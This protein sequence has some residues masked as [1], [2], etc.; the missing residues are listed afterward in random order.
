M[1]RGQPPPVLWLM[2]DERQGAALW[3]A[4]ARLPGGAGII[5]RHY[6]TPPAERR[7][8]FD[9][10]RGIARR[11]RLVLVLAGPVATAVAW[12]ADGAHGRRLH[13]GARPMLRTAP[14]HDASELLAARRSGA[15]LVLLSPVFP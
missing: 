4:L 14:A 6:R 12:Q 3:R 11:R 13:R 7:A 1:R 10:V 9:R 5:F 8:L 15:D 2:T